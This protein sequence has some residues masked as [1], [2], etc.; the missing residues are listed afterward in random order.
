MPVFLAGC[1]HVLV[2]KKSRSN[3]EMEVDQ[4]EYLFLNAYLVQSALAMTD[5]LERLI[6]N[7]E[8]AD[9]SSAISSCLDSAKLLLTKVVSCLINP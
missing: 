6:Y 9:V 1:S 5:A 2:V 7:P 4:V 3:F 8:N